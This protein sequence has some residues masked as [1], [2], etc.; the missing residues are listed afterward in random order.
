MKK[1]LL[2]ISAS[3]IALGGINPTN[4]GA[5]LNSFNKGGRVIIYSQ[6]EPQNLSPLFNSSDSA[7]SVYN[8]LYSGLV[9]IDDS[10]HHYADLAVYIPTPENRG[11]VE[12]DEGMI[13]TYKLK[14]TAFWHDGVPVTSD[15]IIFT[16][17]SY[18]NPQIKKIAQDNL[19]GYSKIYKIDAP[20]SKT[21]KIYF[22][23]KYEEY[24]DLFRYIF[25]KTWLCSKKSLNY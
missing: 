19:D 2:V 4:V 25:T 21:V 10:F 12:N 15:D 18:K 11:V 1:K 17:Q 23:E 13:V 16:W 24:N 5:S 8:L 14:D 6:E 22:S 9:R 7:K 20:D 3:L